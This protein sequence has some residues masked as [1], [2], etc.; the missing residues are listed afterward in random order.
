MLQ[1]KLR[2][3]PMMVFALLFS[4]AVPV[5]AEESKLETLPDAPPLP[6]RMESGEA[7]EPDINIA[8]GHRKILYEY[9]VNGRLYAVKVV[10]KHGPA[11][12]FIDVDGDGILETREELADGLLVSQWVLF[13]W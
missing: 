2:T 13:S 12:Y 8:Q 4:F 11:Y 1:K 9:R 10:P 3:I 5:Q 7:M 6:A